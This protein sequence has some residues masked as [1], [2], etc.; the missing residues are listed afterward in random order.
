[1]G[2]W[3]RLEEAHSSIICIP[4][5]SRI[6]CKPLRNLESIVY[7][8]MLSIHY[9]PIHYEIEGRRIAKDLVVAQHVG[10]QTGTEP[11]NTAELGSRK[12]E[13]R[14]MDATK[15]H[16]YKKGFVPKIHRPIYGK[17]IAHPKHQNFSLGL[18]LWPHLVLSC[19]L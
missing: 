17:R 5:H 16:K 1:M 11:T 4:M 9:P 18:N 8:H 19:S 3:A 10:R 15:K 14:N 12:A 6:D 2:R 13:A 7:S